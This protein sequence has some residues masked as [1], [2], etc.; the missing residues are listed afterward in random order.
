MLFYIFS[1]VGADL[2][3]ILLNIL[4]NKF[5]LSTLYIILAAV[6]GAIAVIAI[7]VYL[8]LLFVVF[9]KNGLVMIKKSGMF[10]K[11]N[12]IFMKN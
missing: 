2:L 7:M 6:L 4:F 5:E 12:V 1:I 10:Q 9:Q 3:I 11:L 8:H